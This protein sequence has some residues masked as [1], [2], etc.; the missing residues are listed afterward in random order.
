MIPHPWRHC[1]RQVGGGGRCRRRV[2]HPVDEG[3]LRSVDADVLGG[4]EATKLSLIAPAVGGDATRRTILQGVEADAEGKLADLRAVVAPQL[5]DGVFRTGVQR[6]HVVADGEG[7]LTNRAIEEVEG[8]EALSPGRFATTVASHLN[9]GDE[10][11]IGLQDVQSTTNRSVHL[12]VKVDGGGRAAFRQTTGIAA[13]RGRLR[14]VPHL[15]DAVRQHQLTLETGGEGNGVRLVE[16]GVEEV[17]TEADCLRLI[18]DAVA[19]D[20]DGVVAVGGDAGSI[21]HR[22]HPLLVA[23]G[24]VI[25]RHIHHV[26]ALLQRG[27]LVGE[28]VDNVGVVEDVL[29]ALRAVL[30]DGDLTTNPHHLRLHH[31]GNSV[32]ELR[33]QLTLVDL[34]VEGVART[35]YR[36]AA[37]VGVAQQLAVVDG[38]G[39]EGILVDLVLRDAKPAHTISWIGAEVI[40]HPR[41]VVRPFLLE[42]AVPGAGEGAGL[43]IH[44]GRHRADDTIRLDAAGGNLAAVD[45]GGVHLD[46]KVGDVGVGDVEV[47]QLG[48]VAPE[49]VVAEGG[50][51][52]VLGEATEADVPGAG[53]RTGDAEGLLVGARCLVVVGDDALLRPDAAGRRLHINCQLDLRPSQAV[54]F[55]ILVVEAVGQ[56][57]GETDG[58]D[59]GVED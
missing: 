14:V 33:C 47:A 37:A 46:T 12:T 27:A 52:A 13:A 22:R 24:R 40:Q 4:D 25:P 44:V 55:C 6:Q 58:A 32:E 3:A 41:R 51:G 50:G 57:D 54:V 29:V 31:A 59:V 48:V 7:R 20:V 49:C 15:D 39:V 1:R 35:G 23:G 17:S 36:R 26:V 5:S 16:D 18:G 53:A 34:V 21:L 42:G 2:I 11:A 19:S 30:Q 38:G 56:G 28:A 43:H 45:V 9:V 10:G 8:V